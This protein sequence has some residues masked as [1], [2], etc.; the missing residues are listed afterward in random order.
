ML[1]FSNCVLGSLFK[2][3]KNCL[4]VNACILKLM[5]I[6]G[7][8]SS[9]VNC[10][11]LSIKSHGLNSFVSCATLGKNLVVRPPVTSI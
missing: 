1:H 3:K 6:P 9:I 7:H 2:F 11:S 10:M 5:Y 8:I 4:M